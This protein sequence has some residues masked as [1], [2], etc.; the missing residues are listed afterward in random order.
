MRD[1]TIS[2]TRVSAL[3]KYERED[4]HCNFILSVIEREGEIKENTDDKYN[5]PHAGSALFL[6]RVD[7]KLSTGVHTY[8]HTHPADH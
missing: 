3:S 5:V 7:F 2:L 6:S 1:V 4:K 8:T